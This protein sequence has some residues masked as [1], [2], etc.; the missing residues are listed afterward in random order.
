MTSKFCPGSRDCTERSYDMTPKDNHGEETEPSEFDHPEQKVVVRIHERIDGVFGSRAV[1][2]GT[3][4]K[5]SSGVSV[6][7]WPNPC[8]SGKPDSISALIPCPQVPSARSVAGERCFSGYGNVLAWDDALSRA[9][10]KANRRASAAGMMIQNILFRA[11][12]AIRK[13]PI[14]ALSHA[15]RGSPVL[16]A[17]ANSSINVR[18]VTLPVRVSAPPLR[19]SNEQSK[20][21]T[22]SRR[23]SLS[24]ARRHQR[25]QEFP[26]KSRHRRRWSPPIRVGEHPPERRPSRSPVRGPLCVSQPSR[27]RTIR[28]FRNVLAKEAIS[29]SRSMWKTIVAKQPHRKGGSPMPLPTRVIPAARFAPPASA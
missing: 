14:T 15:P 8:P 11:Q 3:V 28:P 27:S 12:T 26:Q 6:N 2:T 18:C 7:V 16:I 21:G 10:G 23:D 5:R 22:P 29:P 13:T 20:S 1:C 25:G 24:F 17:I 4:P 9:T 19:L